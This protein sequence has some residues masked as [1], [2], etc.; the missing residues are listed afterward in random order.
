[1]RKLKP[2]PGGVLVSPVVNPLADFVRSDEWRNAQRELAG[3]KYLDPVSYNEQAEHLFLR[4][5]QYA[6]GLPIRS[7]V[8]DAALALNCSTETVKRY[9]QKHSGTLGTISVIGGVIRRKE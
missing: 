5:A 4:L 1:M 9:L 8:G 7:F 6:E 2:V 3:L